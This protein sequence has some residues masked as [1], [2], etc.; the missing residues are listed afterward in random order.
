[1]RLSLLE[2]LAPLYRF[3]A[4]DCRLDRA[5]DLLPGRGLRN[6]AAL[7]KLTYLSGCRG[8]CF[9]GLLSHPLGGVGG[10]ALRRSLSPPVVPGA[11]PGT[12]LRVG[13]GRTGGRPGR[14]ERKEYSPL[15]LAF[16]LLAR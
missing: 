9:F 13:L 6:A 8:G 15:R 14:R 10:L 11:L 16:R 3:D 1:M 12:P 7:P 5:F 2:L 4:P